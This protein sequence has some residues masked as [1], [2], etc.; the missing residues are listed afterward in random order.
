MRFVFGMLLA[1]AV[2][3]SDDLALEADRAK[4]ALEEEFT[5]DKIKTL[6]SQGGKA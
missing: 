5:Q 2:V 4:A 6:I 3:V 1:P